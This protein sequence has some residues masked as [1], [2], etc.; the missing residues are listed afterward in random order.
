LNARVL[1][2]SRMLVC[3]AVAAALAIAGAADAETYPSK[4]IRI[5]VPAAPGGGTDFAARI[6]GLKLADMVGQPVI[7]DTRPGANNNLGTELAAKAP[8]DGYTLI[9]VTGSVATAPSLFSRLGYDPVR[10]FAPITQLASQYSV[11]VVPLS[12]PVK[13]V[14]EFVAWAKSS[15]SGI[16]YASGGSGQTGHLGFELLRSQGGFSAVHVPFKGDNPAIIATIAGD[17]DVIFTSMNVGVPHV[18]SGKVR[19]LAIS[20]LDRSPLV[21]ELPTI[22]ESGFPGFEIDG[23]KGLLAPARTPRAVVA[24]LHDEVSR[25]LKMP[26][27]RERM[28]ASGQIP[29]SSA[30]PESFAAYVKAEVAKWAITIKQA[31]IKGD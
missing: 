2:G 11:L 10:D 27:V 24:R 3:T 16:T 31:G 9:V 30:T 20:S 15:K 5:I 22:A 12:R 18:R 19:G 21:P 13:T 14:K 7:M 6:V 23:W 29:V 8:P 17:V 28:I 1:P 25:L 4:P 26:D